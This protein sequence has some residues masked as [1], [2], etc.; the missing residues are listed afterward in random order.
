MNHGHTNQG[1][2]SGLPFPS[3]SV[4]DKRYKYIQNLNP[5]G[6]SSNIMTHNQSFQAY[7]GG[8][9]TNWAKLGETNDFWAKRHKLILKRPAEEL[10]DLANDP[11]ELNNLANN[12]KLDSI[13]NNLKTQV[14][15]WMLQ[16]NDTGMI[17]EFSVKK[18]QKS[19]HKG[20]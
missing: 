13:K 5:E 12:P 6:I 11:W 14:Q 2:I 19:T 17:A 3:R 4:R 20:H 16:Q 7:G 8:W 1:I 10:Y 9:M 15:D 18:R